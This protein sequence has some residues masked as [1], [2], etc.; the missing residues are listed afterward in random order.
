[1]EY[2]VDSFE[3]ENGGDVNSNTTVASVLHTVGISLARNLPRGTEP[4][5]VPLY[6]RL[7][8]ML[9]NDVLLGGPRTTGSMVGKAGIPSEA[10]RVMI[11]FMARLAGTT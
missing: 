4:N 3:V 6:N 11:V 5:E 1:M 7:D 10:T 2:G 9:V 8:A